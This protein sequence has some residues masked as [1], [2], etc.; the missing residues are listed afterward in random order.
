MWC[1]TRMVRRGTWLQG[2][3]RCWT[4]ASR[5]SRPNW[6]FRGS[7]CARR[8]TIGQPGGYMAHKHVG[9]V[10]GAD[11]GCWVNGQMRTPGAGCGPTGAHGP[12]PQ[13]CAVHSNDT[14]R[15]HR[16]H[17]SLSSRSKS[18]KKIC[19]KKCLTRVLLF[20]RSRR[21]G[22]SRNTRSEPVRIGSLGR[23]SAAWLGV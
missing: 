4:S 8:S 11:A 14:T 17:S 22:H 12:W 23:K 9:G 13:P 6:R 16:T 21:S 15:R 18:C 2:W 7:R 1:R 10:D 20:R 5:D 3:E 19:G